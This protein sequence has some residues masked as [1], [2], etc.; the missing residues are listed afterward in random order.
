MKKLLL[1][2]FWKPQKAS[3]SDIQNWR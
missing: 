2:K 1:P 3:S